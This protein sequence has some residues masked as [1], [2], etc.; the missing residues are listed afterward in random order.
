MRPRWTIEGKLAGALSLWSAVVV[1]AAVIVT[2]RL[3]DAFLGGLLVTGASTLCAIWTARRAAGPLRRLLRAM[4]GAV[5]SY[6]DGDFSMSL[7]VDRRDELGELLQ[8]HNELGRAL[9]EQRAHLA[10]RELLLDT[11]TQNSPVALVL[12]DAYQRVVYANIAA[13]HLLNDGQTLI[14]RDFAT[15]L[16]SA[17]AAFR[18]AADAERD[19]LFSTDVDGNEETFYFSQRS[20]LQ[21]GRAHRLYLI[22]RLT[23]ELSRQEVAIWKKLIRVLSHELNNSLG[24]IA[25]LAQSGA[26]LARRGDNVELGNVFRSIHERADHL[27]QFLSGYATFAKLPA[28]RPEYVLWDDLLGELA[29]THRCRLAG[30]V[31]TAPG[32]FDRAQLEQALIN[33]LRNAKETGGPADEVEIEVRQ[34]AT[35]QRIEVR[36]RGPGMSEAVLAQALLPFYSTKRSGTGLGL[37]LA[38]EITEA[39]GGRLRIANRQHGGLSVTLILPPVPRSHS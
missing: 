20:L 23:R 24:P 2:R 9:R 8:A 10:Q 38:R 19:T 12:V 7:V 4:E 18:V 34:N 11:I 29:R 31:P 37:A 14:G 36:D 25:S 33:L 32:W 17:P 39:H 21:R 5:E 15:L 1:L 27:H 13:R 3:G 28:P 35:E 6:R 30:P 16:A 22:K 26:E